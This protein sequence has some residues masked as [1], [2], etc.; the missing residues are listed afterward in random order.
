MAGVIEYLERFNRK[1]RF[2]LVGWALGNEKFLLGEKFREDLGRELGV[3]IPRTAFVAMDYHLDWLYA[4]LVLGTEGGELESHENP[5]TVVRRKG[6][7]TRVIGAT[8]E[9]I[10]LIIA[11]KDGD[12]CHIVILEAKG[13]TG[14]TNKQMESKAERLEAYFGKK[15]KDPKRWGGKV[16]PHFAIVSPKNRPVG[17]KTQNWPRWMLKENG[18]IPFIQMPPLHRQ[19]LR[20]TR[21]NDELGKASQGGDRWKAVRA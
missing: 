4:S 16:E 14:W 6:E 3:S 20:T 1:E 8:Q 5:R 2:L 21:W 18:Q 17:L 9:D 11:Y 13:V 7:K 15:K 10:D 12:D 19:L